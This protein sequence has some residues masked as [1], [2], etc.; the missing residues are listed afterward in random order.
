[1]FGALAGFTGKFLT[2]TAAILCPL[3]LLLENDLKYT[4]VVFPKGWVELEFKFSSP[5]TVI[6]RGL[7]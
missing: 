7:I 6:I 2:L 5:Y 1:M 3:M 4:K